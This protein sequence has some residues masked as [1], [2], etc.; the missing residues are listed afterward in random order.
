VACLVGRRGA[1]RAWVGRAKGKRSLGTPRSRW[2]D[3]IKSIL[4]KTMGE[5][6][7]T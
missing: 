1:Y 6:G 7:L 4:K 3:N 5:H 2:E